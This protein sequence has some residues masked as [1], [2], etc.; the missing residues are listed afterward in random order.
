M[1]YALEA[2]LVERFGA[3][4][5]AQRT[6]RVNGIT[7][8]TVVLGRALA[9][10]DAEIDG[11]LATRYTLP[12]AS[13]PPLI[14][15]LACE[16]ARYRLYDDGVPPTVRQRYEDTV[17]LLKRLASGEVLLAGM[18]SVAVAGVE[19]V[20]HAFEPRQI[21]ADTLQGFA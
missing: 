15:R 13:T 4:E 8:E 16:I 9:D 11:Y 7:I 10:A 17:S 14:N 19:Q 3:L 1:T 2:D 6:D 21:T 5:L 12:L 18:E 20:Y